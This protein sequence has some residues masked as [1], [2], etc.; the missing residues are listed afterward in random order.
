MAVAEALCTLR[1]QNI[2]EALDENER[3]KKISN[4]EN[5]LRVKLHSVRKKYGVCHLVQDGS[6]HT[7]YFATD[8]LFGDPTRRL[9]I[10]IR[11][12]ELETSLRE[13]RTEW[14]T[15][16]GL[17]NAQKT[18]ISVGLLEHRSEIDTDDKLRPGSALEHDKQTVTSCPKPRHERK[19]NSSEGT[20][21]ENSI[22]KIGY[23]YLADE[24][25]T[26][27]ARRQITAV[28]EA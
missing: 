18:D 5:A 23:K 15:A 7:N 3:D 1:L 10:Q 24:V 4:M 13:T 9:G 21:N 6:Q 11:Y 27:R 20:G 2:N 22:F 12:Q 28:N 14:V 17:V 16:T 26:L 8:A 19:P 25:A